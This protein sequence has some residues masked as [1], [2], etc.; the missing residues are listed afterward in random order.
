M[1]LPDTPA[2]V[3]T[4][5]SGATLRTIVMPSATNRLPWLSTATPHPPTLE[6]VVTVPLGEILLVPTPGPG[7]GQTHSGALSAAT[8]PSHNAGQVVIIPLVETLRT[9]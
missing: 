8:R 6:T 1:P 4:V 2:A 3:V 9:R 7:A 5:P